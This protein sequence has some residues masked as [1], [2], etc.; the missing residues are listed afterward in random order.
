METLRCRARGPLAPSCAPAGG[1]PGNLHAVFPTVTKSQRGEGG[2]PVA[3]PAAV[4]APRGT[5][6]PLHA[7]LRETPRP[8]G[9]ANLVLLSREDSASGDRSQRPLS[10]CRSVQPREVHTGDPADAFLGLSS[11]PSIPTH[12]ILN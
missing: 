4:Q 1:W 2:E 3:A 9:A 10:Y 12:F 7:K 6:D 5:V 11:L 8:S